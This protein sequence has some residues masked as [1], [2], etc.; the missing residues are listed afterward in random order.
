M[1]NGQVMSELIQVLRILFKYNVTIMCIKILMKKKQICFHFYFISFA[2][3]SNRKVYP[4]S[5]KIGQKNPGIALKDF[6]SAYFKC[7]F[8]IPHAKTYQNTNFRSPALMSPKIFQF[9]CR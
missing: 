2:T 5:S 1:H 8:Q 7:D 6:I 4:S 3:P 9:K